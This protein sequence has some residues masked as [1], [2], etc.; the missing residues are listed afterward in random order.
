MYGND[1]NNGIVGELHQAVC[2]CYCYNKFKDSKATKKNTTNCNIH[3]NETQFKNKTIIP[4]SLPHTSYKNDNWNQSYGRILYDGFAGTLMTKANPHVCKVL[5]PNQNRVVTC[6]E[7]ARLQGF[8][9]RYEFEGSADQIYTQI[10]NAVPPPMAKAI[11]VE[12]RK[13]MAKGEDN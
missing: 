2:Q 4:W 12:I 1:E 10:G 3:N 5:H 9:D 11:G 8:P 7:Y 6:R 13:A